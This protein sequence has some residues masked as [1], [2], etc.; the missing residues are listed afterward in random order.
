MI[1]IIFSAKIVICDTMIIPTNCK[2]YHNIIF[3]YIMFKVMK[4]YAFVCLL[5]YN[6]I[7]LIKKT[8]KTTIT[9]KWFYASAQQL[10]CCS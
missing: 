2:L 6:Y 9:T 7:Y 8:K 10:S 5:D 1:L 4:S 3:D